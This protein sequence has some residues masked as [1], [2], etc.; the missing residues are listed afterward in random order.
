[1]PVGALVND[2]RT[3]SLEYGYAADEEY[4]QD[5]LDNNMESSEFVGN[6]DDEWT[7]YLSSTAAMSLGETG[8]RNSWNGQAAAVSST[9]SPVPFNVCIIGVCVY[10][11]NLSHLQDSSPRPQQSYELQTEAGSRSS[12]YN[13]LN[14]YMDSMA[15]DSPEESVADDYANN[16]SFVNNAKSNSF[17]SSGHT[18]ISKQLQQPPQE[19]LTKKKNLI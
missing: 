3:I 19:V 10:M 18:S 16:N 6:I 13:N 2:E 9:F 7:K 14:T 4:H 12:R 15:V 17:R 5:T 8:L 11:L 1:M